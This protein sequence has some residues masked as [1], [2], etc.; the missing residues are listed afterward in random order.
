[1]KKYNSWDEYFKSEQDCYLDNEN[2]ADCDVQYEMT[3]SLGVS[4]YGMRS[5]RSYAM[6]IGERVIIYTDAEESEVRR[7]VYGVIG[8]NKRILSDF[9]FWCHQYEFGV[10]N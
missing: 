3:G 5:I 8:R 1:M 7:S 10:K 4:L 2:V 6:T 9:V